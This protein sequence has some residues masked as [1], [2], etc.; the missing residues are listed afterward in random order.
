MPQRLGKVK[1]SHSL[2]VIAFFGAVVLNWLVNLQKNLLYCG[3]HE[4]ADQT[5]GACH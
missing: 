1:T 5:G 2:G 4:A 3:Q